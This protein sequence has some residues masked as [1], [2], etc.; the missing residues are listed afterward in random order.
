MWNML[1][2]SEEMRKLEHCGKEYKRIQERG[3]LDRAKE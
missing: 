3:K 1:A 2:E